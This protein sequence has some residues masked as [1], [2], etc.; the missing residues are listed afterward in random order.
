MDALLVV[1]H[2]PQPVK[3]GRCTRNILEGPCST[4]A[5]HKRSLNATQGATLRASSTLLTL[6]RSTPQPAA[7]A[8]RAVTS[9]GI[10][11]AA[12]AGSPSPQPGFPSPRA[13]QDRL[14]VL[15]NALSLP[16]SQAPRGDTA[17]RR[18][19]SDHTRWA[20]GQ[21]RRSQTR[22]GVD[23]WA[24]RAAPRHVQ[25]NV[26]CI[27]CCNFIRYYIPYRASELLLL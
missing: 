15:Q 25:G 13:L 4:R 7:H 11:A 1:L 3:M 9:Q 27:P 17:R 2:P 26:P 23:A 8:G 5:L 24:S 6:L 16:D 22:Q 20:P 12:W 19:S 14:W 18:S 21:S 10:S